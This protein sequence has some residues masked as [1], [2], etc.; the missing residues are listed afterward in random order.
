[1]CEAWPPPP[2]PPLAA[3]PALRSSIW[4]RALRERTADSTPK[5]GGGAGPEKWRRGRA[6]K[7]AVGP[8]RKSGG[9]AGPGP[10]RR[11]RHVPPARKAPVR[12]RPFSRSAGRAPAPCGLISAGPLSL[13]LSLP[14]PL[15]PPLS[16]CGTERLPRGRLG[17][18]AVSGRCERERGCEAP[19]GSRRHGASRFAAG[20]G[21]A[22]EDGGGGG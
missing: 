10:G 12:T 4:G 18:S 22:E 15:P 6:G 14:L 11:R 3:R 19:A 9:G 7:V 21:E 17:L 2:L 13:S 8:G 16:P 20:A 1:V 5:S